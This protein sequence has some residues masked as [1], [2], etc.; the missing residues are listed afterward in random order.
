MVLHEGP[1]EAFLAHLGGT[2]VNKDMSLR[3]IG[4]RRF[5]D[6]PL[7]EKADVHAVHAG[8]IGLSMLIHKT[9]SGVSF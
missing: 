7:S 9:A 5:P 3:D 6:M 1:T 8:T 4:K 2:S